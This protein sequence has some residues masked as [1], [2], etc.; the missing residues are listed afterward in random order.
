MYYFNTPEKLANPKIWAKVSIVV[1]LTINGV[2]LH[3]YV[4]PVLQ[5][6]IGKNL[7]NAVSRKARNWMLLVGSVSFVSWVFPVLLGSS[8]ALNFSVPAIEILFVYGIVLLVCFVLMMTLTQVLLINKF[9]F[10][11][12]IGQMHHRLLAFFILPW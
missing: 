3:H 2:L 7:L 10:S 11:E 8:K 6:N 5:E 1:I 12:K 4:L 9:A